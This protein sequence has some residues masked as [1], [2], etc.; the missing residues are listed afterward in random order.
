VNSQIIQQILDIVRQH[1]RGI[2][3]D[4]LTRFSYLEE[5][6]DLF[7]QLTKNP[8][9]IT[10]QREVKL[11]Q[12]LFGK[13]LSIQTSGNLHVIDMGVG[14]GLKSREILERLERMGF[15]LFYTG[16]DMSLEMIEV[17]RENQ[18]SLNIDRN[19]VQFN[20]R[21]FTQLG[22]LLE[23]PVNTDRL[24]LLLGNTLTNEIDIR[25]FLSSFGKCLNQDGRNY[26]LVGFEL[27][28]GSVEEIVREYDNE[29]NRRL[30]VGPLEIIGVDTKIHGRVEIGFNKQESRIEEWYIFSRRCEIDT[31]EGWLIFD[32]G[33]RILLSV[34][35]KPRFEN[36]IEI[37]RTEPWR[38]ET[39][40]TDE[41]RTYILVLLSKKG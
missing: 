17:A 9:Y 41:R 23:N 29:Q 8:D 28:N 22:I 11:L 5:G 6:S 3:S 36:A 18:N 37:F 34:T 14:D 2:Y 30:T 39:F 31:N 26:F 4:S 32:S 13:I 20:F 19:Y 24:F 33:D 10:H 12:S 16:I 15:E 7:L 40:V 27:L 35:Y 21:D 25:R 38:I 1:Q